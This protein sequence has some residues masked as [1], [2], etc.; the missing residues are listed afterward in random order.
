M[1]IHQ[2]FTFSCLF[3]FCCWA[4]G[5][6]AGPPQHLSWPR[7]TILPL[8]QPPKI[9]GRI[10]PGEWDSAIVMTGFLLLAQQELHSVQPEAYVGWTPQALYV[11]AQIPTAPGEKARAY[12]TKYDGP[13]WQDDSLEVHIDRGHQHQRNYQF[14]I[15]ALG[16]KFEALKG[17][18]SFNASWEGC[19][20]NQPG[21][22]TAELAIPW[23]ALGSAPQPGEID[24]FNLLI[25]SSYLG[26]TLTLAQ[27]RGSAHETHNYIHL[28]YGQEAALNVRGW[29]GLASA[30]LQLKAMGTAP[31]AAEYRLSLGDQTVSTQSVS[32]APAQTAI[33]SLGLPQK[34]NFPQ[35]GLYSM[36]LKATGPNGLL[37]MRQAQLRVQ[38]PL[39]I[40]CSAN[41]TQGILTVRLL[42]EPAIF[43]CADT[44][45][46]LSAFGPQGLIQQLSDE[47]LP[48]DPMTPVMSLTRSQTPPGKL[49]LRAAVTNRRT[50]QQLIQER[51]LESPLHPIWLGT[52]EGLTEIV[53]APW[54][55]VVVKGSD[56]YCWG[57]KYRFSNGP[58]PSAVLTRERSILAQPIALTGRINGQPL[59]WQG[60]PAR[61]LQKH[62]AAARLQ[63]Q[64]RS[65]PLQLSGEMTIEFDGMIRCDLQLTPLLGKAQIQELTLEIPLRPEHARYL[66]HFPGRWGSVFN[67]GY[68]PQEG[69]QSPFKPYVWLG[70][71]DRGFSW[72][73]ESDQNWHPLDNKTALTIERTPQATI[74]KCHLIAQEISL[75][76]PLTYTF[77]FQATPVKQPEK[78]VWDYRITHYGQY[79]LEKQPAVI[80][81]QIRY[82]AAGHIRCEEGTFECWYRVAVD[83]ENDIPLSQRKYPQNREIFSVIWSTGGQGTNAGLYWNG[84][85]QGL[86]AWARHNGVVTDNPHTNQVW[87]AGQ[88]R[89]VA[90]TWDKQW[91]RLYL[92][93]QLIAETPNQGFLPKAP[94]EQAEI[95]IGGDGALA[96][97][98]EV[99]IL[100]VAR[101]PVVPQG[102]FQPDE[103][104]LLLDHFEDYGQE[105]KTRAAAKPVGVADLGLRFGPGKFGLAP[106][107]EPERLGESRLEQL[108]R[109]GVRTIC[110]HEHWTPYQSYPRPVEEDRPRL[111]SLVEG[112]HQHHMNLLL[113]MSR[114]FAD[115]CPEWELHQEEF[116]L[117]PRGGFYTR[118][119]PQ[120]AYNGC[121]NSPFKDFALYYLAQTLD[122]FGHD[123]WYLD[124]PEWPQPCANRAHGCG[125]Q[126]PDGSWRPT[127]DIF[128]TRDFMKRLYILTRQRKP[129]G[130]L[131]VHNSTVMVMPTLSWA[132]STWD[133]EHLDAISAPV[134]IL[135]ILPMDAFRTEFMGRQ[136]G[137]APE[138]LVYDGRPYYAKDVLAYTL[139]HGVL[140]R[141][142][143]QDALER[144]SALWRVHDEF[145]FSQGQME[146]YWKN[147]DIIRIAGSPSGALTDELGQPNLYATIW[148]LPRRGAL[149]VISNL[150]DADAEAQITLNLA[151]LGLSPKARLW[152]ALTKEIIPHQ[153]GKFALPVASWRYRV[154]RLQ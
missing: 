6:L 92:D 125:Y 111:K 114:Q 47:R 19:A 89:H 26:G 91:L 134:K 124:G 98:D 18:N 140:I 44:A 143:T 29:Q 94:L 110:F 141:P 79:G 145:P 63:G 69:W 73:C 60:R 90:L 153:Q 112:L 139:L 54:T 70:D 58:L 64:A 76:K 45:F 68:L 50:Q 108:A 133:G 154:L 82:P 149:I 9:D 83:S 132:T 75:D 72:F 135:D 113:Y 28:V 49:M 16:T 38:E 1:R 130:Q 151:Q 101:A 138:F 20:V 150:T 115:I 40:V 129:E 53:P 23:A 33:I 107:W 105:G 43:P 80:S 122:E 146:G 8:S 116:L 5:V 77:G 128:A 25:N 81:G 36:Q 34:Q 100:S 17:D 104:T 95:R 39:R 12:I 119:P 14:I 87:K 117:V 15:N 32:L 3:L 51:T 59:Q 121:W 31:I 65:G 99:R 78:T 37:L 66:Y 56:V 86:V 142:S 84:T 62:P 102:P 152:D 109:L 126:A 131:N 11:A 71:E 2:A 97:I 106:T 147:G 57:R 61:C 67:A 96:T 42:T 21:Q 7:I 46:T 88:W 35:P 41:E 10:E 52:K 127:W 93:G 24:G 22:W 4:S 30:Q 85:S 74:L 103:Q 123:G 137:L 136:W 148:T 118:Q 13:V 144:L 27:L 48:A 120:K 55:P